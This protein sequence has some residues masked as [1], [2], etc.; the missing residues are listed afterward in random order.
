MQYATYQW[1]FGAGAV[2][3]SFVFFASLCY[4]AR[5]LAAVLARPRA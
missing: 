5:L 4:G 2:L 3:A 1:G